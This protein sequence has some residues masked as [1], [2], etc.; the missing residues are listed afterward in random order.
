MVI[1]IIMRA[2]VCVLERERER[3][4]Y[5]AGLSAHEYEVCRLGHSLVAEL[6]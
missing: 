2:R 3:K 4:K 1:L 6:V 5:G